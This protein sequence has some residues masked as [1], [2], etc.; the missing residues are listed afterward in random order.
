MLAYSIRRLLTAIPTLF[1][2]VSLTFFIIRLAPGDPTDRFLTPTMSPKVKAAVTEKFGLNESL[3]VQYMT[4]MK[5]VIINFDFGD[6]FANGRKAST[7]IMDALPSTLLLSSL[8]LLF[9]VLLGIL[10]GVYSAIRVGTP[11]D[12][13]ITSILVFFYSVPSFWLGLILLGIFSIELNWLPGSQITSIF[14][15]RLSFFGKIGDYAA[16]LILPVLTL[17]LTT[18]PVYGRFVRSSMVEVLNSDFIASARARGLSERKIVFN[19]GLRNAL[20]PLISILGTSFPALFSGAVIVEVIYSLPG[21]GR[22][23]VNAALGRDYPII[24]AASAVAFFAVIIGNILS[25]IGYAVAD[26]RVRLG[27]SS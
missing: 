25:D 18:A 10:L 19:Y 21:M 13:T 1:L 16:H 3:P 14:H 5:N 11:I 26:P 23:M 24:M 22:V 9:G 4:W 20:L 6:S 7:V 8:S 17:G 2:G 12:R 15:E 27:D